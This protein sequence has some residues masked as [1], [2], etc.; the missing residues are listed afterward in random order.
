MKRNEASYDRVIRTVLA[1]F[2][3]AMVIMGIVK[4]TWAIVLGTLSGILLITAFSG[5]CGVYALLG[6]STGPERPVEEKE[7]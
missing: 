3:A 5:F 2:F 6:I 1:A 4:G 7:T